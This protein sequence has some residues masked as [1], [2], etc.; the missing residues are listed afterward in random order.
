M[1]S[2]MAASFYNLPVQTKN[3]DII[4]SNEGFHWQPPYAMSKM[5]FLYLD[6]PE[7]E[8]YDRFALQN[9]ETVFKNVY[10]SLKTGGIGV[11]QFGHKGQVKKLWDL[12]YDIFNENAFKKYASKINFRC[13]IQLKSIF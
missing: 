3:S 11:F 7:K 4:I 8:E 12:V 1:I 2:G 10:G 6:S 9:L 5:M 13:I